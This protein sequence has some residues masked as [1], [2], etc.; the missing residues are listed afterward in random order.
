MPRL[1]YCKKLMVYGYVQDGE[2]VHYVDQET[3]EKLLAG[4][5]TERGILVAGQPDPVSL[6]KFEALAGRYYV[7]A[8]SK[9][10]ILPSGMSMDDALCDIKG[11]KS[12]E[13]FVAS[14]PARS[15][16]GRRP[17]E[18][19]LAPVPLASLLL[20]DEN[21]PFCVYCGNGG[22]VVEL[23]QCASCP[24]VMHASCPSVEDILRAHE[25]MQAEARASE[26][27]EAA[28][29]AETED[30]PA[31]APSRVEAE[32][33][34]PSVGARTV[35]HVQRGSGTEVGPRDA[36][37]CPACT[38][39]VCGKSM[40]VMGDQ[41]RG[42][43][44]V[45]GEAE[46]GPYVDILD[47]SLFNRLHIRSSPEEVEGAG[48]ASGGVGKGVDGQQSP[49]K[50]KSSEVGMV[51]ANGMS[52]DERP[53]EEHDDE[54]MRRADL[55]P[56]V[57]PAPAAGTGVV[58]SASG[59]RAHS[60]CVDQFPAGL[61]NG[62]PFDRDGD[63]ATLTALA[64]VCLRGATSI[65]SYACNK[66]VSFQIIHAAAAAGREIHGVTPRYTQA[67]KESLRKIISAAWVVV[68]DSYEEIWDSRTGV[69]LAPMMLQGVSNRPYLDFSGMFIAALFIESSIVSVACFRVLGPVA[70]LPI[71]ATRQELR[72]NKA[73]S[74]LLARLDHELHKIGVKVLMTQAT[75]KEGPHRFYPYTPALNPPGVALPPPGQDAFGFQIAHKEHVDLVVAREGFIVP[76]ISWAERETGKWADW[77]TWSSTLGNVKVDLS[78]GADL[79]SRLSLMMIHAVPLPK[80][81][82]AMANADIDT[83]MAPVK[84]TEREAEAGMTSDAVD[85]SMKKV[86]DP[87]KTAIKAEMTTEEEGHESEGKAK[88]SR[89]GAKGAGN[90]ER[91]GATPMQI[92]GIGNGDPTAKSALI[93]KA[94]LGDLLSRVDQD[95]SE[96]PTPLA[97]SPA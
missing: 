53:P 81:R 41:Y 55:D 58:V 22:E 10:I 64:K 30:G 26:A 11:V 48:N 79:R 37:Y 1:T 87:M 84:E 80:A 86:D 73:A 28:E 71:V 57:S 96:A 33:A 69:N 45:M 17:G 9:Y 43:V 5:I 59:A 66:R 18:E 42:A 46:A 67:Q 2:T 14:R 56:P 83:D 8:P 21:D 36:W 12:E 38:C 27:S 60:A 4:K 40:D 19:D 78:P 39:C 13:R 6:A 89:G 97:R 44:H 88:E 54:T 34:G 49:H 94:L 50:A 62:E 25:A 61:A 3:R 68:K 29:V 75:Y 77:S 47:P 91:P 72:G 70:E 63:R 74:T 82:G 24:T 16:Q 52:G 35:G 95:T 92:D 51:K 15:G 93:V 32:A 65:G 23:L 90:A 20:E 31:P 76:G 7:K 85:E